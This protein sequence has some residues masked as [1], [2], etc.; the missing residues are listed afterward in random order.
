MGRRIRRRENQARK[1]GYDAIVMDINP[2]AGMNGSEAAQEIRKIPGY[3]G[4]PIVAVTGTHRPA[5]ASGSSRRDSRTISQ[6][7][8]IEMRLW[9][10]LSQLSYRRILSSATRSLHFIVKFGIY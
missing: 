4:I 7:R 3:Q 8:S 9:K 1:N 5:T 6:N 10:S 2:G